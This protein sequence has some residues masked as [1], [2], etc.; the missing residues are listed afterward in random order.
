MTPK[1]RLPAQRARQA[2]DPQGYYAHR[3]E[4]DRSDEIAASY[5]ETRFR[6]SRLRRHVRE[7][8]LLLAILREPRIAAMTG[9]APVILDIPAGTGRFLRALE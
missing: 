5:D 9:A 7:E 1:D 8:S 2:E 6:G 3:K 4:H